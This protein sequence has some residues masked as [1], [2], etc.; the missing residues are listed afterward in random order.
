MIKQNQSHL[1]ERAGQNPSKPLTGIF[2][3]FPL[4]ELNQALILS[5]VK[6]VFIATSS[7]GISNWGA[8]HDCNTLSVIYLASTSLANASGN[9][10]CAW[11]SMRS[12]FSLSFLKLVKM[13][14]IYYVPV[15]LQ[16]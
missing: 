4:L 12:V 2:W 9:K 13:T 3:D 6:T 1:F 10:V 5:F 15:K 16:S 7:T 14:L 11:F 8:I